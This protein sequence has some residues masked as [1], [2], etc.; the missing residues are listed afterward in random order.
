MGLVSR[1]GTPTFFS[2]FV[3]DE[4]VSDLAKGNTHF[5]LVYQAD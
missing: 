4:H 3:L 1:E 5:G 2:P